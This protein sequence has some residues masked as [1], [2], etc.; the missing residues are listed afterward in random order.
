MLNLLIKPAS[1]LCN[2]RCKYCFYHDELVHR[3]VPFR[4]NMQKDTADALIKKVFAQE[5]QAVLFAF[6][7]GEP[8]LAGLDFFQ[9]F[10]KKVRESNKNNIQVSYT[11]QTNGILLNAQWAKFLKE[12]QFLVGLSYDSLIHDRFQC[13]GGC[14]ASH[15]TP[16]L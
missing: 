14:K 16:M 8:M 7:G 11:I 12:N 2:M 10:V 13:Q 5:K 6:Q 1:G 3:D 9:S 4:G 15:F